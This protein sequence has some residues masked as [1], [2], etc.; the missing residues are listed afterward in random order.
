[1]LCQR[2]NA[3]FPQ[4]SWVFSGFGHILSINQAFLRLH[5]VKVPVFTGY[6][7]RN[8]NST[9]ICALNKLLAISTQ[10][11]SAVWV[12]ALQQAAS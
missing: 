1:M 9:P 6:F 7:T 3:D 4:F 5:P 12:F 11:E 2:Q 8:Q 10:R